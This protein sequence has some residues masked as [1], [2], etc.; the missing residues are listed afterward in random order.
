MVLPVG[1]LAV[2]GGLGGIWSFLR[3]GQARQQREEQEQGANQILESLI[4]GSGEANQNLEG[5]PLPLAMQ[6][7]RNEALL[8]DEQVN[9]AESIVDPQLRS[10]FL[11]QSAAPRIEENRQF[12]SGQ[13]ALAR[14]NA[15][16][17]PENRIQAQGEAL[18]RGDSAF[19]TLDEASGVVVP[20]DTTGSDQWV[21][22]VSVLDGS[23]GGLANVLQM[24][25]RLAA[26]DEEGLGTLQFI[27]SGDPRIAQIESQAA[28]L[29]LQLRDAFKTGQLDEGTERLFASMGLNLGRTN[30]ENVGDFVSLLQADPAAQRAR[31]QELATSLADRTQNAL[32]DT[33]FYQG[34]N[35]ELLNTAQGAL[36]GFQQLRQQG[37]PERGQTVYQ[38]AVES[39]ALGDLLRLGLQTVGADSDQTTEILDNLGVN[40]SPQSNGGFTPGEG[41]LLD[42]INAIGRGAGG[43]PQ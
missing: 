34:V 16:L 39:G 28:G 10:Q 27:D 22:N 42:W 21:D 23:A 33:R 20:V 3:M 13:R 11:I 4:R 5:P 18:Q 9:I 14:Q 36:Q 12:R 24:E 40:T 26:L 37:L 31:L 32:Y 38:S 1:A 2:G 17:A 30:L 7:A 41:G 19:L 35:P 6:E 25:Q 43:V 8:T 29:I 15:M